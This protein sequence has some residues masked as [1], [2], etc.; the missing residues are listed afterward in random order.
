MFQ[1]IHVGSRPDR[2]KLVAEYDAEKIVYTLEHERF[3]A[4]LLQRCPV[5]LW[6]GAAHETACPRPI[7]IHEMHQ[8]QLAELHEALTAGITDIVER[9]W[10]DR[11]ARFPERMPLE[12][13]EEDLLRWI[14][15]QVSKNKILR[16]RECRG[17]WRPDFLV[18]DKMDENGRKMENFRIT[19]INARFSF[20]A[21][22]LGTLAHEGL[23][24]MGVGHNGLKCATDP[25]KLLDG[26]ISLFQPDLP[27]HLLKGERKGM[28]I[29]MLLHIVR[30]R[31]GL[32]PRLITPAQLRLLPPTHS[33]DGY[34]LCCVVEETDKFLHGPS[35]LLTS[36]GEVVEVIQQV[37]LELHQSELLALEP[38]M[39]RQISLRCFN[40]MRSILLTHDK[41]MLGI[42]KQ[43]IPS[44]VARSVI[45][46]AQAQTLDQG[47]AETILP[48]S[49]DLERLVLLSMGSPG[50]REKYL[51]KPIRSGKGA[52]IVFGDEFGP[53]EWISALQLQLKPQ[54]VAGASCVVQR[55]ITPRLYD[56]VLN[57][58]GV[59]VCYPLIGTYF[60]VHGRLLGLGGWR[61]SPDKI[62]AVSHGGSWICSV[63][64]ED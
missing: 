30:Q 41:R 55:R 7:L 27:L 39:L 29:H 63:M 22:V 2:H 31:F 53:E 37:G 32:T 58:S 13:Q 20:N 17:S 49:R 34:R 24:D 3:Q 42:L 44:L 33:S 57:S 19:E 11:D 5:N 14:D 52:G 25:A 61:S 56:F 47:I 60:V 15:D 28:D 54:V 45:T 21:F 12:K 26:T 48:G 35:A 8:Q 16:Y 10:T 6:P 36:K 46:R 51:L 1:Q 23:Q 9:W 4:S 18:E 38:E 62:C 59:H 43:E 50:L 64:Y 40:D